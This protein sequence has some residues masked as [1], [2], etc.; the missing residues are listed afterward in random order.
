MFQTN[1]SKL[2]ERMEKEN[3]S[4]GIRPGSHESVK[5]WSWIW[6]QPYNNK[7]QWLKMVETSS[8]EGNSIITTEK[9]KDSYEE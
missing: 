6:D 2:C 8:K 7:A 9:V 5:L 4:N 3:R 1:Q